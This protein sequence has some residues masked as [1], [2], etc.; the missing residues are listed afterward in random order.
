MYARLGQ[1]R[2]SNRAD[3]PHQLDWQVVKEVQFGL[4][5]D[6]HQSVWFGHLRGNFRQVP[7]ILT[8]TCM[9]IAVGGCCLT[10]CSPQLARFFS[11]LVT[12]VLEM[13]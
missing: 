4:G 9:M 3:S 6:K 10:A 12:V 1:L 7:M 11:R 5:I 8:R 13:N 2:P